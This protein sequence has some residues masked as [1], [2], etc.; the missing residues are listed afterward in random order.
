M[1]QFSSEQITR[2]DRNGFEAVHS[3]DLE[4]ATSE[5][6]VTRRPLRMWQDHAMDG[7]RTQIFA[8]TA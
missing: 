8:E 7:L 1:A 2:V 5:L 6:T 3:L 4:I